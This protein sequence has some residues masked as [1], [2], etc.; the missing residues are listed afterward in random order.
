M[1]G[2]APG[3]ADGSAASSAADRTPANGP[4]HVIEL[5]SLDAAFA[6]RPDEEPAARRRLMTLIVQPSGDGAAMRTPGAPLGQSEVLRAVNARGEEF[7]VKLLRPLPSDADP[8]AR[9]GRE[10]ALF[11]EYRNHLAVM[12]LKGFPRLFGFGMTS[13]GEP[14]ILME[15][16]DGPTLLDA[17]PALPHAEALRGQ[18][19]PGV[20]AE[21]VSALGAQ[22][23]AIL[24]STANLEGA[25]AHR[26]IS[27]RNIMLRGSTGQLRA[28]AAEP[29]LVDLG[30][31][32]YVGRDNASFT[33]TTDVWRFATPDYAPPEMLAPRE[34]G[35]VEERCSPAVDVYAL[36]GVLYRLYAGRT[37]YRLGA[38]AGESAYQVKR[39]GAHPIRSRLATSATSRSCRR[40]WRALRPRRTCAPP[41]GRCS[42]HS[43]RGASARACPP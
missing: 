21:A 9:K 39:G 24:A 18:E 3:D 35:L 7:A 27:L 33:M 17:L 42:R 5:T 11:E 25:F 40:S 16:I 14:M 2:W 13:A 30:S 4:A 32:I 6:I 34:M 8:W 41:P 10:A 22:L 29:C 20:T 1:S 15:W 37:P 12:H 38:H 31:S 36:A 23:W 26:D 28:G 43:T 19:L